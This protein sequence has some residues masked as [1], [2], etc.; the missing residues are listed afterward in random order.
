MWVAY[1]SKA[2]FDKKEMDSQGTG[3]IAKPILSRT[4]P[5][6]IVHGLCSMILLMP[7]KTE[8]CHDIN[9][10]VIGGTAGCLYDN[11]QCHQWRKRCHHGNSQ[12]SVITSLPQPYIHNNNTSTLALTPWHMATSVHPR[13]DNGMK[14]HILC[15]AGITSPMYR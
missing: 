11:L 12:F 15:Y 7:L 3:I 8:S 10:V 5:V 2:K 9:L 14:A 6:C 4:K 13:P 1:L